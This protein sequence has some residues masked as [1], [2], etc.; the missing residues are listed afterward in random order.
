MTRRMIGELYTARV[1]SSPA[2]IGPY[3]RRMAAVQR[4]DPRLEAVAA[5]IVEIVHTARPDLVIEHIGSTAVPGLPGKGIVDLGT[6]ADPADIP[7]ITEALFGLGFGPQPGPDRGC[8]DRPG[9][10]RPLLHPSHPSAVLERAAPPRLRRAPSGPSP[11][12][13]RRLS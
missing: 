12:G 9:D 13:R 5:R 8:L 7:A 1:P 4:W 10:L 11:R 2:P 3:E 6:E